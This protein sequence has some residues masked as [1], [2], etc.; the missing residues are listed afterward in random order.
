METLVGSLDVVVLYYVSE[1]VWNNTAATLQGCKRAY[2]TRRRTF[3]MHSFQ[4]EAL[5]QR[6]VIQG[7]PVLL[8]QMRA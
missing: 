1:R 4:M 6:E 3:M 2:V 7:Q 5:L 8:L